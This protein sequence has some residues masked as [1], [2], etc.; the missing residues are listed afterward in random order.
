MWFETRSLGSLLHSQ[1]GAIFLFSKLGMETKQTH[2]Y[3]H[4]R[5]MMS[6]VRR[7]EAK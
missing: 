5:N 2:T 6:R 1:F 7:D 4:K 3:E